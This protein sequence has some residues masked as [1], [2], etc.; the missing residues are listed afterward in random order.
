MKE[1]IQ[2][3]SSIKDQIHLNYEELKENIVEGSLKFYNLTVE[4]V[5]MTNFMEDIEERFLNF[6]E[7]I[8]KHVVICCNF[9]NRL[10]RKK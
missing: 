1:I 6:K 9:S 7:E 8:I 3:F 5:N 4:N 2:K 10:T